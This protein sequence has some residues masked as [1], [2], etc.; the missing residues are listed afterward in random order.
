V[1]AKVGS[2]RDDARL[3]RAWN[4]EDLTPVPR[5]DARLQRAWNTE[6]LTPVPRFRAS[7]T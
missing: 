5:D 1:I 6:D 7:T 4:T 3:Q 2:L